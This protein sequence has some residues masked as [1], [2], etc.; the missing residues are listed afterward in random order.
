VREPS[1][2]QIIAAFES[3]FWSRLNPLCL[4][5]SRSCKQ[6]ALVKVVCVTFEPA[7]SQVE[8][9]PPN[10]SPLQTAVLPLG[11]NPQ[12]GPETRIGEYAATEA[13]E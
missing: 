3:R 12:G 6:S 9:Q 2:R 4:R 5:C 7:D 13:R 1:E 8:T 11:S 10:M